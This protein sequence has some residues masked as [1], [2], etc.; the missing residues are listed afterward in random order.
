MIIEVQFDQGRVFITQ[1]LKSLLEVQL[2][3]SVDVCVLFQLGGF[4]DT[5]MVNNEGY[6]IKQNTYDFISPNK[7][8][9]DIRIR[10]R[11]S[12]NSFLW[13]GIINQLNILGHI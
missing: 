10:K 13:S 11:A 5:Y 2:V 8:V 6:K 4:R 3:Y 1:A 9:Y 12:A 7:L